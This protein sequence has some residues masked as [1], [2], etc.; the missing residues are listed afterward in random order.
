[1]AAEASHLTL[2]RAE[3][4]RRRATTPAQPPEPVKRT[5]WPFNAAAYLAA[6]A[7]PE[8]CTGYGPFGKAIDS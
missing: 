8:G 4:A 2:M 1:M 7:L 3:R 5:S 6:R